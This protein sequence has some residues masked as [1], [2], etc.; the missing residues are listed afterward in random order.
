MKTI[1]VRMPIELH[2]RL[3][4][5]A[6]AVR[7]SLNEL[8]V[9]RLSQPSAAAAASSQLPPPGITVCGPAEGIVD[10]QASA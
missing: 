3:K 8:C 10:C 9:E 1:T 5:E 7:K 4:D 6:Y 2:G